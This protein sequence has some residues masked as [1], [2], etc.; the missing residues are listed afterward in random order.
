MDDHQRK[1]Y[2]T[3]KKETLKQKSLRHSIDNRE[4]RH[5]QLELFEVGSSIS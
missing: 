3:K 4:I 2:W 5:K 1:A